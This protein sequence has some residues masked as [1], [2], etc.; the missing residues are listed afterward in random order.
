MDFHAAHV[1]RDRAPTPPRLYELESSKSRG[2]VWHDTNEC[3]AIAL[4]PI[5]SILVSIEF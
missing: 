5:L 2:K 1:I 4:E 3:D